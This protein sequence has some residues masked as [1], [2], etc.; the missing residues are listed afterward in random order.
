MNTSSPPAAPSVDQLLKQLRA[1]AE[2]AEARAETAESKNRQLTQQVTAQDKL[3]AVLLDRVTSLTRRLAAA[4]SRPEQ[5]ALEFELKAVQRQ[6][7]DLNRDRF[8]ETSERRG[9]PKDAPPRDTPPK[10]PQT[11]H[12]PTPQ[13]KLPREPQLHLL[14]DADKIC[15]H[16]V[17]PRPLD[18]WDGQTV[19][20]EEVTVIERTFQI[21]LHQRQV[22]RCEGC[23]HIE[24]ALGPEKL[25]AR[26]R[27]APEFAVSV[28]ADKYASG[29]PLA[30]QAKRMGE[31]GLQVTTQTLWDQL[32]YLYVLLLP[33]YLL[34]Q[35]QVLDSDVVFV[36][37]TA[38]RLMGKGKSKRWWVWG[39]TDGRRVFFQLAPTRGV[40]AARQLLGDYAG[41]VMADRYA[42]YKALE[43]ERT[44]NGGQQLV[45]CLDGKAPKSLPTPDYTLSACWMHGRRGFVKATRHGEDAAETA[46]DLIAGV[47]AVEAR[48]RQQVA[49]IADREERAAALVAARGPLRDTESRALVGQLRSWLDRVVSVPDLPLS[50]AVAWLDN[51]WTEL[52]RFLDDPRIPLDNGLAER[53]I[54]GVVVG[55]K[56]YAGSRS[57]KGTQVAAL[58]YSLVES[59]RLEGVAPRAYLLEAT[60]RAIRDRDSV[61]LPEDFAHWLAGQALAGRADEA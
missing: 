42:V 36:D 16:C 10:K 26:G 28:A 40:A 34:L 29:L 50:K 56:N 14:D 33:S 17:P 43:K 37:E 18:A 46:L 61:F 51:G 12:G 60:R 59:C 31:Q 41:I 1:R 52:T 47:Y 58:F 9:R 20:S 54:R 3:I 24:T 8:G 19:D 30:R 21:T 13:P 57:E 39:M 44:R 7:N 22:Y 55:R 32:Q 49:S 45:I 38:W 23:G 4:R 48:A 2:A 6:L 27:Y 35:Q 5:I 25:I 15:P 11:G 53:V